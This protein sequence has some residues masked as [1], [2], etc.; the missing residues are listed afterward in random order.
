[1]YYFLDQPSLCL[2]M[3]NGYS[4]HLR[5]QLVDLQELAFGGMSTILGRNDVD[6]TC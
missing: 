2:A 5:R 1:M 4:Q 6:A 3:V